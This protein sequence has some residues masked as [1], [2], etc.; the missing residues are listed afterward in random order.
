MKTYGVL[1]LAMGLGGLTWSFAEDAAVSSTPD[2]AQKWMAD[3]LANRPEVTSCI[4]EYTDE[5]FN[6]R[7]KEIEGFP[8]DPKPQFYHTFLVVD[9]NRFYRHARAATREADGS[10]SPMSG[11]QYEWFDGAFFVRKGWDGMYSFDENGEIDYS[12]N[13]LD[14]SISEGTG[15]QDDILQESLMRPLLVKDKSMLYVPYYDKLSQ[16]KRVSADSNVLTYVYEIP[17]KCRVTY[18]LQAVGEPF[19]LSVMWETFREAEGYV[20]T[21]RVKF[22]GWFSE[23][24]YYFPRAMESR[25][26]S[27]DSLFEVSHGQLKIHSLNEDIPLVWFV[28]Q[29][30]P[31]PGLL[32]KEVMRMP[33]EDNL[34]SSEVISWEKD[35][36]AQYGEFLP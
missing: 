10:L 26:E 24:G 7:S 17:E 20:F 4:I 2:A 8:K 36:E 1:L 13:D 32:I 19:L 27:A 29:I 21:E 35:I 12:K 30:K 5:H 22:S 16:A 11:P 6:K 33:G 15:V 31:T 18:E 28:P 14:F 23:Q 25:Y 9:G 34:Y 3:V